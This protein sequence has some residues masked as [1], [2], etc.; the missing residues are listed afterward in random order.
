MVSLISK[1]KG[2]GEAEQ[3]TASVTD[4]G[5]FRWDSEQILD[6]PWFSP[7]HPSACHGIIMQNE[8][9]FCL[10]YSPFMIIEHRLELL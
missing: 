10:N 5:T 6:P 9:F 4:P 2:N 8:Y 3:Y 7:P 1:D